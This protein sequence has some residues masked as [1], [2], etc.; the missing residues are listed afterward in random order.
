[1]SDRPDF[2]PR[3]AME[4]YLN[5][6]QTEVTDETIRG[7][8][9]RLRQFIF[10]AEDE[11]VESMSDLD[12]WMLDKY[13]NY[14][15]GKGIAS[16]TLS[17]EMQTIKNWLEYLARIE[18]IDEEVPE[19][20]HVP[21]IPDGEESDD[22]LLPHSRAQKL[23]TMFRNHPDRRASTNHVL[24]ELLWFTGARLGGIRGFDLD[25]YHS[26]EEFVEFHH[27]PDTGTP[28]KNATDGER[29]VGLPREV[30]DIVD[31]YIKNHRTNAYEQG[32]RPLLT[33]TKGRPVHNTIRVWCYLATQPCLF[34]DCPHG[35]ERD[36][37]EYLDV[38]AASSCP[39]SV[40]PHRVRTGSITWQLDSGIPAEIVSERVNAT[41]E[42][43]EAHYDKATQRE[44][45]ER[46]RRH[47]IP[48]LQ[49]SSEP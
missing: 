6:R 41:L 44:R 18:V 25:D 10:W 32:R 21:T 2:G 45:L 38:H 26:D 49:F 40:S 16:A 27:R 7:F 43:I 30:C 31:E 28:L 33:T 35:K 37:C 14:R 17:S 8:R 22:E 29:V 36:T 15:R 4:R 3:E 23:I 1:M 48:N 19:K 24:L 11:G 42:V 34:R 12:G 20:V 9:Y 39:S 13:E 47:Y 46:R 5:H